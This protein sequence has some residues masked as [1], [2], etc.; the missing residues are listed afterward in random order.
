MSKPTYNP[1]VDKVQDSEFKRFVSLAFEEISRILTKGLDFESNFVGKTVEVTFSAPNVDVAVPHGLSRA[2][3]RYF[4]VGQSA[5][6]SVY[7]GANPSTAQIIYLRSS[8]AG[9]ARIQLF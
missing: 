9:V 6:M 5:A 8:A 3:T 2:P 1:G 7:D 4:V